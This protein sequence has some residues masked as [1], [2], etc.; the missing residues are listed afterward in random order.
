ML[1][2]CIASSAIV[3]LLVIGVLHCTL[4]LYWLAND[5][6]RATRETLDTD[7]DED[8]CQEAM[9]STQDSDKS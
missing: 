9:L 1:Y 7:L 2:I 3:A 8:F 6:N 4:L 5:L